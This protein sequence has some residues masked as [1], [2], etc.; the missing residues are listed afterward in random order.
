MASV[1][2]MR[3]HPALRAALDRADEHGDAVRID[4]RT[5]WGNPFRM[6]KDGDRAQVIERY[7]VWLWQRI[8]SGEIALEDLA[9]LNSK[10]LFCHCHP[11]PCH[12][13]GAR[14]GRILGAGEAGGG[15][16]PL[17]RGARRAGARL[18]R[19]RRAQDARTR[20]RPH[21]GP[22][23][24]SRRAR[25]AA[26]HGRRAGRR[27]RLRRRRAVPST[28]GLHTLAG[29]QRLGRERMPRARAGR[30]RSDAAA[31]GAP[32]SR[33]GALLGQGPRPSR[34]QR[35]RPPRT[36]PAPA[37][38]CCA[39]LDEKR[40]GRRRHRHGNPPRPPSPHPGLQPR[41]GRAAR[42]APPPR[43]HRGRSGSGARAPPGGGAGRAAARHGR[44][45]LVAGARRRRDRR[46]ADAPGGRRRSMRP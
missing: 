30:D 32:P 34:P 23:Q 26:P 24:G 31:G 43:R 40:P 27:Q 20:P 19:R 46:P 3:H 28:R 2:N 12:G 39:L 10:V 5:R 1:A 9:R 16:R 37:G 45:G 7:R 15:H 21:E 4:R 35:R 38:A 42:G 13:D 41:G 33:V 8:E 25:L 11:L 17:D 22:R 14:A 29:L 18:C 6:G 44:Q 36:R